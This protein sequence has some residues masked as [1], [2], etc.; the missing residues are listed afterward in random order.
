MAE[1]QVVEQNRNP[2]HKKRKERIGFAQASRASP[3]SSA[4]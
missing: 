1:I 3:D 2:L 4:L